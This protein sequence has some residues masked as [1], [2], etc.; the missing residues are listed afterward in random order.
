MHKK[1]SILLELF[2]EFIH[3]LQH[4]AS[5]SDRYNSL[6]KEMTS[7]KYILK[8]IKI[9]IQAYFCDF[10]LAKQRF[11]NKYNDYEEKYR[12]VYRAR[13]NKKITLNNL[14]GFINLSP[15]NF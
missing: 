3:A 8:S 10:K 12:E 13:L 7:E 14:L 15:K 4:Y 1:G 2:Y 11:N 6:P 5:P 9:E